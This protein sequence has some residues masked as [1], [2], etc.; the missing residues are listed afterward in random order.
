MSRRSVVTSFILT[1]ATCGHVGVVGIEPRGG[2]DPELEIVGPMGAAPTD[3]ENP[4]F[5]DELTTPYAPDVR[6]AALEHTSKRHGR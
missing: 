6:C 4:R 3:C 5:V 1:L 2:G